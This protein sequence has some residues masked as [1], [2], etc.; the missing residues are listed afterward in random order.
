MDGDAV[1]V[2]AGLSG[3]VAARR[4]ARAGRRVVVLE[5]RRRIGGRALRLEVGGLPFDAGCEALWETHR[6]LLALAAELGVAVHAGRPWAGHGAPSPP[7]LRA[8]EE[9]I[10]ALAARID[11]ARPHELEDAA[12]LDAATL[13]DRLAEHGA[14]DET[15]ALA[16]TRYAVASSTVPIARMSLLA[17]AAKVAAGATPEAPALRLEGGPPALAGRLAEGLDVRLGS[18]VAALEQSRGSVRARLRD[19]RELE[20]RRAILAVPLTLQ[21]LIRFDPPLAAHRRAAL[22][23]ARYGEA[24]KAGFAFDEPPERDLPELTDAGVLYRPD[25]AVPLLAL[26]AGAGAA[27]R[28]SSFAFPEG[29]PRAAAAVDWSAEPHSRGS[30][31]IFG[32]GQ[33][34]SWGHRLAEPQGRLHFA[35]AEA[36][37]LPSFMEG[38]V[39]AGER[40]ADEVSEAVE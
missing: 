32:P 29:R 17:Y 22:A 33:L 2:G 7:P 11:P 39:R 13:A 4:L 38:A 19:G 15:L 1:V 30:Y 10:A 24:V 5:A 34:T 35:G 8:L 6:R 25:P 9:E 31:L 3:L 36:S 37:D 12:A 28:A 40:A 23:E 16:E 21:R 27:R 26:F 20:G 14:D 18:E